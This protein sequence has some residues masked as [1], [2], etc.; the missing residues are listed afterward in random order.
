VSGG[1]HPYPRRFGGNKYAGNKPLLEIVQDSLGAQRGEAFNSDDTTTVVW[2]EN[3]AYARA[4][5]FDGW[6][7]NERL[8]LQWDPRRTTDMLE[9]WETIFRL[10]PGPNDTEKDR[11]DALVVRWQQFGAIANHSKYTTALEAALGDY[12]YAVE[13]ISSA[14]A[15]IHVPSGSYPWGTVAAG[16]SW[17][18][19]IAHILVRLQKPTGASEGDFYEAAS[20]V[21]QVMDG[22]VPATCTFSWYRGGPSAYA[23]SG[24]PSAGGFFLDETNLDNEVFGT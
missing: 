22:L 17:Y 16:I 23:V 19:T 6:G 20:R 5:T 14:N 1:F 12:F 21:S 3:H 18:S 9:R 13:Y 15:V 8:S 10:R 2:L 24:G 4:I 11:R 7:T